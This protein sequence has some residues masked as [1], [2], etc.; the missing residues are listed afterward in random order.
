M[1][2]Y[3]GY[4]ENGMAIPIGSPV[5]PEGLKVIITVLDVPSMKDRSLEQKKA[6]AAFR[7]GVDSCPSLPSEF[8]E[9]IAT[10]VNITRELEL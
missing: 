9:I 6:L 3:H 4:T 7:R 8:D 1:E 5:I 10:R 2:A